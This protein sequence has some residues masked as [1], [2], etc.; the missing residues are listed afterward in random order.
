MAA[1]FTD[2]SA[3]VNLV[4]TAYDQKV[5]LALRSVPSFRAIADTKPVQQT[6]PGS[7]V[8]FQIHQDLSPA[9]TPLN[10]TTD[11][12]GVSLGNTSQITVTLNEYGNFTVVTKALK[13]FA[14]DS[15]LDSNIA[16]IIAYNLA[17][18]I[19]RII[20]EV[21]LGAQNTITRE[22][23]VTV[24]NTGDPTAIIATDTITSSMIT[25]AV[26]EL[27]GASVVPFDGDNYV[28]YIHPK[29]ARD[30]RA[31]T[32]LSGWRY[33]HTN[34]DIGVGKVLAGEIGIYEGVRFVESSRVPVLIYLVSEDPEVFN[35][36]YSTFVMGREALAEAVAEEFSVVAD[37]TVVDPLKRKMA[38]GWYG[39][40]GW[41]LFRPESL[42][43]IQTAASAV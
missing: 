29:V 37:G 21:L 15:G 34:T 43:H 22:D 13:E 23:G 7:S 42:F 6:Q 10:E 30:L 31:E 25:L 11:P 5:R 35:E 16:N 8:V 2:T 14:L 20:A 28:A 9:T 33:P 41:N 12:S 24:L 27:R 40:A 3:L 1:P 39:I 17:D 19:D 18:S 26:A 4:Q 36:V 38:I 32:D